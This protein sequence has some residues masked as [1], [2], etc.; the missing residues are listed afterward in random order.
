MVL[1][2]RRLRKRR[3]KSFLARWTRP[4]LGRQRD[5][6]SASIGTTK[7]K[8]FYRQNSRTAFE[9]VQ[10]EPDD[11]IDKIEWIIGKAKTKDDK[12]VIMLM[13]LD[14]VAT[15]RPLDDFVKLWPRCKR[16]SKSQLVQVMK[17]FKM[18]PTS[19]CHH[20]KEVMDKEDRQR[21]KL[22]RLGAQLKKGI[23]LAVCK[24]F[25]NKRKIKKVAK[26]LGTSTESCRTLLR[27]FK[28]S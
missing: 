22:V 13:I 6:K 3:Q 20:L 23:T 12:I 7:F 25:T 2:H 24:Q 18:P 26:A 27:L 11:P 21:V 4:G 10:P 16:L 8:K 28:H 5:S 17:Y 15:L 9:S 14:M 1:R 19:S